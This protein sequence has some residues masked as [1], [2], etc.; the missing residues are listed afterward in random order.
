M[1]ASTGGAVSGTTLN[2]HK[3]FNYRILYGLYAANINFML[4]ISSSKPINHPVA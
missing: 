3:A 4:I 2:R 1:V